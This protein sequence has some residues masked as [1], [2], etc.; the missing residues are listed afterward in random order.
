MY[1]GGE[2][3]SQSAIGN[4]AIFDIIAVHQKWI[5]TKELGS[6][7]QVTNIISV[8]NRDFH[9]CRSS[10]TWAF[11]EKVVVKCRFSFE[12]KYCNVLLEIAII[13]E[14]IRLNSN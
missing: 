13:I 3:G 10:G 8:S 11:P 12:G 7:Q 2:W 5:R 6:F 14:S 9:R 1:N 4:I